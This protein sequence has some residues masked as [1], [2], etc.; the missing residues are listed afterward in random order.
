[1]SRRPTS[2]QSV[3]LFPFLAVLVCTMGS[4]IFLLLVTTR[5]ICDR[6]AQTAAATSSSQLPVLDVGLPDPLSE[7]PPPP[8]VVT[9]IP[10]E[11]EPPEDPTYDVR[12]L[13][14]AQR[15]REQE[16]LN[17]MWQNRVNTL[18]VAREER[19]RLLS[20]RRQLAGA[21]SKR[22]A[23]LKNE[24]EELEIKLGRMT[25]EISAS[26]NANGTI[27]ERI[28]LETLIKELRRR[29]RAAQEAP[30]DE[31]KFEVVP[32]DVVSGTS[33][34][35]ILIECSSSGFKFIPENVS[36]NRDDLTG[37]T[38]HVNPVVVGASALINYWT[39]WNIRQPN[40]GREPEP[41]VLLLVRPS[42]TLAYYVAMKMLSDL[43]QP[44]GYELI[45]EDTDLQMPP[46][47]AGAKAALETSIA[48]LLAERN[49][50]LRQAGLGGF[51]MSRGGSPGAGRGPAS[52]SREPA[53]GNGAGNNGAGDNG[54]FELADIM[55]EEGNSKG[56]WERVENFEG[57]KRT[58]KTQIKG[59]VVKGN[60]ARATSREQTGGTGGGSGGGRTLA[61]SGGQSPEAGKGRAAK[62][63]SVPSDPSQDGGGD[64]DDAED[65]EG[66]EDESAEEGSS[67]N[68]RSGKG[69][70]PNTGL[71]SSGNRS[72]PVEDLR[73]R[74]HKLTDKEVP[75]SPEQLVGRHWGISEPSAEIGLEREIRVDVDA[76]RYLIG[77]KHIVGVVDTDSRDDTFAKVIAVLDLQAHDWG[78][79]PPGIFWKPSLRFVIADGGDANYE[80]IH[81]MLE[82]AGLSSSEEYPHDH[83]PKAEPPKTAPV[84]APQPAAPKPSRRLFR[85]ILK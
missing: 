43:R 63:G 38:P 72:V 83:P 14:A 30:S 79:P 75:F 68:R 9:D 4:L 3:A 18:S 81:S 41:Y 58:D 29:L 33:R 61:M 53:S 22:V 73:T 7:A 50:V 16:S 45:E 28:E 20:Q 19:Q 12:A 40:P 25:G 47:D 49:Q 26:A 64:P 62:P 1:M 32:F 6:A 54:K 48:R 67:E 80:R 52:G 37:F 23:A 27:K 17:S 69:V 31:D 2:S 13:A 84:T 24:L 8:P 44:H 55:S 66:M 42:G 77:G 85:G 76:S 35:P 36:I 56:S 78:K 59:A 21:S 70:R 5:M 39:A 46:V 34:R 74:K 10:D 15:Q 82:K 65:S 71:S 51:G 60:A 11:P 57:A